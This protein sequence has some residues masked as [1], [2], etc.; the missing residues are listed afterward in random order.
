MDMKKKRATVCMIGCFFIALSSNWGYATASLSLDELIPKYPGKDYSS[1]VQ[2]IV[3]QHS[4]VITYI[5]AKQHACFTYIRRA[6]QD[7]PSLMLITID[8]Q[9][10]PS[11]NVM[12][13]LFTGNGPALSFYKNGVI[14]KTTT[15]KTIEDFTR[16][17]KEYYQ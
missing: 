5:G 6:I 4:D 8:S 9:K 10:Y 14:C 12:D 1:I 13:E 2:A 15:F 7:F 16:L 3:E 11:F 17:L